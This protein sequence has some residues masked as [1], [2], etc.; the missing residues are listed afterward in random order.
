[1]NHHVIKSNGAREEIKFDKITKR[2]K[3]QCKGLNS[4]FV[5]PTEVTRRVAESVVDGITTEEIDNLIANEAARLVTTHPD[6]SVLAAR[7]LVS[8]WQ[9]NIPLSFSEN[10]GLLYDNIDTDTGQHAPLVSDELRDLMCN[11]ALA[12]AVDRA[13]VHDRDFDLDY[14]GLLTLKRGYLRHLGNYVAE[15]PQFMWMRVALGIHGSDVQAA[16]RCYESMS[17]GLYTHATPTLFNAGTNRAQMSSCFLQAMKGDSIR[18]IFETFLDM[19][20]ISKNAGGIGVH[21]HNIRAK[22]TYIAGTA[23]TSNG[24]IPMLRVMNEEARYVDQG[25]GKRKGSFAVYLEPWHADIQ[26]FLELKKN[27]GKEEMRARD[28]FY[29][30]WVPDLFMERV[31]DNGAWSLMCPH[32][33]PG[34]SDAWGGDFKVLYE[35]YEAEER[36]NKQLPARELWTQIIKAQIET[37]TPYVLFKDAANRKS[38]QQNLGTIKSSN[39]CC[40]IMEVSTPEETAVCNLASIALSKFGTRRGLDVAA[41]RDA[42]YEITFNLNRVIDRNYYPTEPARVSNFRHRPIGIGIQGLA[43]LYATLKLDFDSPEAAEINKLA[44]AA[45]YYGA[46]SASCDLAREEGAYETYAGS[47]VSE[48]RLQFDMWGVTPV[49][50]GELDWSALRQRVTR[51]GLRNSLLVAPMPTASTSQILGNNE[52]FEPFT[53]NLYVR[54]VLSGEF[55]MVNKHLVRDLIELG[56]WN[57]RVKDEIVRHNG[58]VQDVAEIPEDVRRRYRTVWEISMKSIIDQAAERGPYVCQSQSMNLFLAEP[59]VGKVNSMH[60]YS[61]EKGLKTGMYYLRSKPASQA[62]KITLENPPTNI[63]VNF[64]NQTNQDQAAIACSLENPEACEACGS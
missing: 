11:E 37:G 15:T 10:V 59:T 54:R 7:I 12:R 41:L 30:L 24:I 57:E 19:A 23:G 28:L 2:I 61:W 33:C 1:M 25:G 36:Y 14:F 48:G 3:N 43:D 50:H 62:K 47:P 13:V 8:R 60:F 35:R 29:A 63:N 26:D 55:V 34:L 53:S 45:I 5:V 56:L 49:E 44:F 46:L 22:G 31:R 18:G 51:H 64:K 9:K 52:C 6:Y 20:E 17:K 38:N 27:H 16:I 39:L 4:Q 40:E 21:V 42:A 32:K 58:S